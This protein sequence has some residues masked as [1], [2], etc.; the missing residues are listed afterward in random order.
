MVFHRGGV[1][2]KM[3]SN[4]TVGGYVEI[5]D[6]WNAYEISYFEPLFKMRG[7]SMNV[8][9]SKMCPSAPHNITVCN[10]P[11]LHMHGYYACIFI[12]SME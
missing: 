4:F 11:L 1:A 6:H 2:H 10:H 3:D 7:S 9:K 12:E 8:L 5:I